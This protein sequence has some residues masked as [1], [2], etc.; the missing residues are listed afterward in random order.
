MGNSYLAHL[1]VMLSFLGMLLIPSSCQDDSNEYDATTAVYIVT[2]R[3]APTSHN[4]EELTREIGHHFRH[5]A[6]RRN[7]L[8]R[9]RHQN[10]SQIDRRP[11]SNIARV[12]DAWLKKV[13][14]GE[15]Y[16]KLY[17][18]HYLINGFAVLIT[19]QQ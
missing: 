1:V 9:T 12:H 17:S 7:T 5:G 4:Q 6:S 8:K 18:Y 2:L 13:F 10:V 14:K 11:G 3:Q 19:Q 16:L 15:K